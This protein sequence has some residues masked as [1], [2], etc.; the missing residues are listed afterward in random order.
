[1]TAEH[2]I[3]ALKGFDK[4]KYIIMPMWTKEDFPN[5][6]SN[7]VDWKRACRHLERT[8]CWGE[9]TAKLEEIIKEHL[10]TDPVSGGQRIV[11]E[12]K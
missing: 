2:L 10:E 9:I 3:K 4:T 7:E 5:V 6:V 11:E 1:M 12:V 8:E